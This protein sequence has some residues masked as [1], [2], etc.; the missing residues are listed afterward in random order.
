MRTLLAC[1]AFGSSRFAGL[2]VPGAH[3][4]R[5]LTLRWHGAAAPIYQAGT[6]CTRCLP[7]LAYTLQVGYRFGIIEG[8]WN[9]PYR[10]EPAAVG[11]F[12]SR[13]YG[14]APSHLPA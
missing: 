1:A 9:H 13:T 10:F 4:R 8:T 14:M 7:G 11:G 5:V 2:P 6:A 12:L 3:A